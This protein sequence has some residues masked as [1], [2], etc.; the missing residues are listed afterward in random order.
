MQETKVWSPGQEDPL[1]EEMAT[2][3]SILAWEIQQR[4]LAG[5]SLWV[6]ELDTTS[7]LNNYMLIFSSCQAIQK[8][9][10]DTYSYRAHSLMHC[11]VQ[12]VLKR[13][14]RKVE[15]LPPGGQ[16]NFTEVSACLKTWPGVTD[17]NFQD[18]SAIICRAR[19]WLHL[20]PA[21]TPA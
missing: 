1:E 5:Y 2:H 9:H 17:W 4:R 20:P 6:T 13:D 16:I 7:W 3:S 11:K 12:A 15:P 21:Y 8:E 19:H 10:E 14:R 18:T